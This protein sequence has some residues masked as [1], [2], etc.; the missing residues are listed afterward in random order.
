MQSRTD[1]RANHELP[2]RVFGMDSEGRPVNQA[3]WTMDVSR[4]GARL[5]G[6][7]A[8]TTPGEII[9]IRYGTEKAR[10]KIAWVGQKGTAREGQIGV[11]CIEPGK[12][13]W[14]VTPPAEPATKV[15]PISVARA[16][17][18]PQVA[19]PPIG[20]SPLFAGRSNRRK[21]ARFRATG[22]AKIQEVG[23]PSGQW[24][25]LHDLSEGGCYVETSTPLPPHTQVDIT[26]HIDE[27]QINAKGVITV[28]HALVGMGVEFTDVSPLN[29]ERL[30]RAMANLVAA[31]A[32]EA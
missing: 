27:L 11:T 4:R 24:A 18:A 28:K 7:T 3:A 8:F 9:G 2:I 10:F 5:R 22:H 21:S 15:S 12:Y 29:R 14:G 32:Q 13:I 26:V 25:N 16:A 6:V 1:P 19:R 30:Q 17:A 20:L 23:A 31:G